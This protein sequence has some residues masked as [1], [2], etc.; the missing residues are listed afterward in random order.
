[1]QRMAAQA[2]HDLGL[3]HDMGHAERF[4]C[5]MYG[6]LFAALE[7]QGTVGKPATQMRQ[8]M[9][10]H[11]QELQIDVKRVVAVSVFPG[12]RT[13]LAM[14]QAS[15]LRL[16]EK[17][18]LVNKMNAAEIGGAANIEQYLYDLKSCQS[19]FTSLTG[20]ERAPDEMAHVLLNA[21]GRDS[22]LADKYQRHTDGETEEATEATMVAFL[23]KM[24]TQYG[25]TGAVGQRPRRQN[26]SVNLVQAPAP[27]DASSEV[28]ENEYEF[29]PYNSAGGVFYAASGGDT[30]PLCGKCAQ[31][32]VPN[33]WRTCPNPNGQVRHFQVQDA[34]Q[35]RLVRWK[36]KG[37]PAS[38]V[39]CFKCEQPG[40]MAN[41][42]VNAAAPPRPRKRSRTETDDARAGADKP[43]YDGAGAAR[44]SHHGNG[45]SSA[46]PSYGSG[47]TDN[48]GQRDRG[49]NDRQGYGGQRDR[50]SG[51]RQLTERQRTGVDSAG[52]CGKCSGSGHTEHDCRG[53]RKCYNCGGE[54]HMSR[55]CN[56]KPPLP[57]QPNPP[58]HPNGT[59]AYS[60]R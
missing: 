35:N 51:D 10:M 29:N 3:P 60:R 39:V 21:I 53:A 18:Q 32:S 19:A 49:S 44:D 43:Y 34:E 26:I 6:D 16:Q 36:K 57:Q 1:M 23:D 17:T 37:T 50:G 38:S 42:C 15:T 56:N 25:V 28:E 58:S 47:R 46:G 52:N 11:A 20:R 8:L 27:R 41:T 4:E 22:E 30:T 48:S 40:H 59:G 12:H 45:S 24:H 54:G 14:T 55:E 13:I 9:T 2:C 31:P 5:G 33:H 7:A